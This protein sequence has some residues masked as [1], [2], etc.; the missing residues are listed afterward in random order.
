MAASGAPCSAAIN[1]L[2][3]SPF[4]TGIMAETLNTLP[5]IHRDELR[6]LTTL[7]GLG[8]LDTDAERVFDTIAETAQ[9]Q[10]GC[11]IALISFIDAER[12]WFKA[13]RGLDVAETPRSQAFCAHAVAADATIVV[14]DARDDP[15]FATN[16]IVTGDLDIRFYAGVPVRLRGDGATRPALPMGTLCILDNQPRSISAADLAYLHDLAALVEALLEARSMTRNALA[17]ATERQLVVHRLDRSHRQFRQA[18]RMANIGSWR[19]TLADNRVEWSDQVYVIHGLLKDDHPVLESALDFYPANARATIEEALADTIATGRSFTVETDF[20]T[21]LGE[22]R[23]IRAMGELELRAGAP[24]AVIGVFQDITSRYKMEQALRLTANID[25][26]TQLANRA[27]CNE[28]IDEKLALARTCGTPMALL[29]ID[30]DHFKAVNDRCGHPAGDALL[31]RVAR[32]LRLPCL[33]GSFA[34]RLG[35]DE[36]VL[37]VTDPALLLRLDAMAIELLTLL[38]ERIDDGGAGLA[39]S[40]TIGIALLDA[41]VDGRSE[42]MHRADSAL[43]EAK[44]AGRGIARIHGRA[45]AI[46]PPAAG[47]LLRAVG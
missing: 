2:A 24:V 7:A 28:M 30:L 15:R 20:V 19:L 39:V 32:T 11:P 36:F 3:C 21:L 42:L 44:R 9:R 45:E 10:F 34:A 17:L 40:A 14:P 16:P 22:K 41:S 47:P 27:W 35:G 23:R 18:E 43:Y 5:P 37:V 31:Q 33:K 4:Y 8:I 12:Q 13:K 29:M 46:G 25:D 6:R 26:L 38:R 1:R